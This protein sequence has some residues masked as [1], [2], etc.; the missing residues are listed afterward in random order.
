MHLDPSNVSDDLQRYS[1]EHA[2]HKPPCSVSNTEEDLAEDQYAEYRGVETVT[3]ERW[4]IGEVGFIQ[5]ACLQRAKIRV[6]KG[7]G[8]TVESHGE[9]AVA[10]EGRAKR[11]LSFEN[12]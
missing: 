1:T 9:A 2:H 8:S 3:G 5:G 7:L 11:D 10:G 4:D 6:G 12:I